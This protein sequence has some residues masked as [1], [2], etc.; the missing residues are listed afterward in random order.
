M[1]R[2]NGTWEQQRMEGG[3][4][5]DTVAKSMIFGLFIVRGGFLENYQVSGYRLPKRSLER[6]VASFAKFL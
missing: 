6:T 4:R 1:T 2:A 5:V 3:Q